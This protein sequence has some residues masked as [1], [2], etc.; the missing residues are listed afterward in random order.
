MIHCS[1]CEWKIFNNILLEDKLLIYWN[2]GR[3]KVIISFVCCWNNCVSSLQWSPNWSNWTNIK[4]EGWF[5]FFSISML[6]CWSWGPIFRL[7]CFKLGAKIRTHFYQGVVVC[8]SYHLAK[9]FAMSIRHWP[10]WVYSMSIRIAILNCTLSFLFRVMLFT[11][12]KL[13]LV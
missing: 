5:S 9:A 7:V 2:S 6:L 3:F 1:C 11:M 12:S 8:H 13:I 10:A 4:Y